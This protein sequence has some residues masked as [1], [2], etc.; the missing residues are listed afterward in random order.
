MSARIVGRVGERHRLASD[1]DPYS[2]RSLPNCCRFLALAT[3]KIIQSR[4]TSPALLFHFYF[5]NT[6]R[7][8]RKYPLDTLTVRDAAHRESFVD[9]AA[10][11]ADHDPRK[12][13]Y[14]FFVSLDDASVHAHAITN[15]KRFRIAFL[16]LLL[17]C[18]DDLI[19][20]LIASRAA[21]GAHSHSKASDLQP[22]FPI[23]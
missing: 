4:A 17:N 20:K 16:L 10:P 7:M 21:A 23:N 13:L 1:T 8:Q 18:I 6:R 3:A 12:D 11:P 5:C 22:K 15:R 2:S 9:P 14:S 19:H